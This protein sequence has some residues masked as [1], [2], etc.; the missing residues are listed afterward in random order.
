MCSTRNMMMKQ[1]SVPLVDCQPQGEHAQD[2]ARSE[3]V[4]PTRGRD[5][6]SRDEEDGHDLNDG[7][8]GVTTSFTHA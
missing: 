4:Q 6:S 8:A 1:A 5:T 3:I 7:N 2:A